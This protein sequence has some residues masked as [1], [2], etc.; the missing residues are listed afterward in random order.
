MDLAD[1]F[2]PV[3]AV[4]FDVV[5]LEPGGCPFIARGWGCLLGLSLLAVWFCS[6]IL[7]KF[8]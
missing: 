2:A 4:G 8:V 1:L 3:L 5:L 6:S 7:S